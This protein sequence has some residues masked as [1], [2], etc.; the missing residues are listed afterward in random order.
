MKKTDLEEKVELSGSCYYNMLRSII[1]TFPRES[2]GDLLGK[3]N[4]NLYL[5]INSYPIQTSERKYTKVYYG[6]S[7]AIKRIRRLNKAVNKLRGLGTNLLGGYHSHTINGLN[8]INMNTLGRGDKDF[9]EGELKELKK[10]YW[11]EILLNIS[12]K[13]YSRK[14]KR[15]EYVKYRNGKLDIRIVDEEFHRY[16]ITL[17]AYKLIKNN[18][19]EGLKVKKLKVRRVK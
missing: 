15:G 5:M 1:E 16:N 17:S 7:Q 14:Q 10:D 3:K 12:S 4:K 11:I 9:I 18:N 13:N 19:G 8:K 6:N 2:T